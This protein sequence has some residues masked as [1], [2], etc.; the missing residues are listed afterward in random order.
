MR[1]INNPSYQTNPNINKNISP[2]YH[3]NQ[4]LQTIH[5]QPQHHYQQHQIM[6]S[7]NLQIGRPQNQFM[8]E[9][10]MRRN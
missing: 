9:E 6:G 4:P 2:V 1:S 7:S 8:K 10:P 3:T 5:Q